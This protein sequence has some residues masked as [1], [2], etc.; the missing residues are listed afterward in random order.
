MTTITFD[1]LRFVRTLRDAGVEERQAEAI[2][3]AV[4][5]AASDSD[6]A[7]KADLRT[8]VAAV[9]ADLHTEVAAVKADLQVLKYELTIRMGGMIAAGVAVLAAMKFFGH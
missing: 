7:T 2:A 1:T 5:E 6:L 4:K 3:D 9:R 8:E